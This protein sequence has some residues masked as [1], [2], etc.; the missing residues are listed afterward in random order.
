MIKKPLKHIIFLN[1]GALLLVTL[2]ELVSGW[3]I[4]DKFDS[5]YSYYLWGLNYAFYIM[6]IIWVN[7]FILIPFFL[8][9]KRFILYGILLLGSIYLTS[10]LKGNSLIWSS[11]YKFFFFFLYT[12]GTGMAAFFLRRIILIQREN[13]EKEKLQKEIELN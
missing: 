3:M 2:L 1:L 9:K 10:S 7:H 13:A 8:D 4:R 6:G 11:N 5:S 12:T